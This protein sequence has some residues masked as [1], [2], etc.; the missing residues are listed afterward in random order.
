[1]K[2][3]M[4]IV[5]FEDSGKK[6][7]REAAPECEF[8]FGY[9]ENAIDDVSAIIGNAPAGRLSSLN[10]LEWVQL[11]SAGT[12]PYLRP[13][14]LPPSCVLTNATGAFGLAISEHM[15]GCVFMLCKK[16]HLYRDNQNKEL[17]LDRGN[18]KRIEGAVT[19]I[20][21]LGDIG[22]QFAKKMK[23]LGAYTIGIKRTPSARPGYVDELYT[24]DELDNVLPRADIVALTL[25]GTDA[26]RNIMSRQRLFSLK[27][28]AVLI[29]IG[30][31]SAVDTMALCDALNSGRLYGAAL[32][33]TDPEPLPAGHPLWKCENAFITPHISGFFHLR[34]TYDRIIDICVDNAGRYDKGMPLKNIVDFA[35]GYKK[36][37]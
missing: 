13:G 23:A 34:D 25:P 20:V 18:V 32:D 26:T 15:V 36:N 7:L 16:L 1:M 37:D 14:I 24:A 33:V 28:G 3:V 6:R 31:G 2:K 11:S 17:W 19:L 29:N 4:V 27:E 35:T 12:E 5:P 30:R 9:D 10:K 22:G 8:I 21:G